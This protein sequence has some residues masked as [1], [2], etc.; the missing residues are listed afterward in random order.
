ML[1]KAKI[2]LCTY[3]GEKLELSAR[4]F[5]S[6]I[7]HCYHVADAELEEL[8]LD[9]KTLDKLRLRGEVNLYENMYFEKIVGRPREGLEY[10]K[11]RLAEG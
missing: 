1:S 4:H 9:E 2:Y 6:S 10:L 8:G 5:I 3:H 11:I 7:G